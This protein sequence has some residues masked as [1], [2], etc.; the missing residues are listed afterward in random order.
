MGYIYVGKRLLVI[1]QLTMYW[2]G[3]TDRELEGKTDQS[4][5]D[6]FQ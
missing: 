3:T 5:G 4:Y 6:V 1:G 2:K